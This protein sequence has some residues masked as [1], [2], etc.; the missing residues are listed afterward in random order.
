MNYY[1]NG[2]KYSHWEVIED[3]CLGE[4]I[5]DE[6]LHCFNQKC[7][8]NYNSKYNFYNICSP[9]VARQA[10]GKYCMAGLRAV[11]GYLKNVG[12]T[13]IIVETI[14][15]QPVVNNQSVIRFYP[16]RNNECT[17]LLV[18]FSSG[19]IVSI[20]QIEI[21]QSSALVDNSSGFMLSMLKAALDRTIFN[22]PKICKTCC[23]EQLRILFV[24][25]IG[26]QVSNIDTNKNS[27]ISG[28]NNVVI[29]TGVGIAL[30][31]LSGNDG[32]AV[33]LCFVSSVNF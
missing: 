14:A 23:Q 7:S 26:K 13:D 8:D 32:I 22:M 9:K 18:Q 20:C 5:D 29:A 12:A 17:A 6:S 24:D 21:I 31:S 19:E 1:I 4:F 15:S 25:N 30:I 3:N 10:V 2:L 28:G 16:D 11:L 27:V 33:N